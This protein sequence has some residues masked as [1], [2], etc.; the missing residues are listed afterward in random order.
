MSIEPGAYTIQNVMHGNFAFQRGGRVEGYADYNQASMTEIGL[1]LV[2]VWSISRLDNGKH[3]IRNIATND[4][5]ASVKF[6][7]IEENLITTR[8][9]HQWAIKGTAVKGRYVICTTGAHIELFWGLTD[10]ELNTPVSLRDRPNTPSNQWE[11][12]KVD[13]WEVVGSLRG[14]LEDLRD[15]NARLKDE[16][17]RPKDENAGLWDENARLKG[18]NAG[19]WDENAGLLDENAR[20]KGE[21][22]RLKGENVRL[23]ERNAEPPSENAGTKDENAGTKGRREGCF[24][25]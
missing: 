8:Y 15:E 1:N 18:K 25:M 21:N 2:K 10:G 12:T 17:A 24:C 6:P 19:R 5:A 13:L 4:Y 16:S 3:T 7:T 20:L 14:K 22:A 9:L 11:L 23:K